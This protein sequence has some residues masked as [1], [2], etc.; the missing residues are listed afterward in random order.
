MLH[1]RDESAFLQVLTRPREH[2]FGGVCDLKM[3]AQWADCNSTGTIDATDG[4]SPVLANI[5]MRRSA[6]PPRPPERRAPAR[7][8]ILITCGAGRTP[9]RRL[10]TGAPRPRAAGRRGRCAGLRRGRAP[11]E[12]ANAAAPGRFHWASILELPFADASF[13]TVVC[14]DVLEHLATEDVP[15]RAGRTLSRLAP[16]RLP[17]IATTPDHDQALAPDPPAARLVGGAV[18]RGRIPQASADPAESS[19]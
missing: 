12:F 13:E 4:L 8:E 1:W 14:M 11:I 15:A 7:H 19:L 6:G 5:G 17:A 10:R 3:Q 16:L 18:L 9:G 2:H